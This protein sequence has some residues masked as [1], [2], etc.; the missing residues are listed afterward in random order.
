MVKRYL[1]FVTLSYSYSILRPIQEEIW[2]RGDEAAWYIESSCPDFLTS[3][4]KRLHTIGEVMEYNPRAIFAPG[5]Y[6]YDFFPGVKVEVFHGLYYKRGNLGDHYRIRG[7]FDLYCVTSPLFMS[8]FQR[9]ERK[10]GYF[11]AIE[12]GWSKFDLF[13]PSAD[14]KA[15]ER[16]VILFA[17]T[18]SRQIESATPLYD[19]IAGLLRSEEWEWIFSFHPLTDQEVLERYRQLALQSDRVT[20]SGDADRLAV[21]DRADVM[22]SDSSSA[23]YEF[24]WFDKPVVTYRNPF[25][26]NHLIDIG[27]PSAL[28][29][30][31]MQGLRRDPDLMAHIRSFMDEVHP[32]RDGKSSARI[33]DAVDHFIQ[34][35]QK[36]LKRKPLNLIRKLKLRKKAG[37]FPFFSRG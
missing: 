25:P 8:T 10:H 15:N 30:A 35:D 18:F 33:L 32:R 28:K 4:E 5:N 37:Y 29:G 11:K 2:R 36:K 26:G 13:R 19:T 9:L 23:I 7:F 22:L 3:D 34:Y 24:L 16:P 1:F 12:T 6:I 20:F 21:Y 27:E 17:P 14:R 31:L